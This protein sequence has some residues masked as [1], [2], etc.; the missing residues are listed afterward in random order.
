[1]SRA[2]VREVV[3]QFGHRL[4]PGRFVR[5]D[6]GP[7]GPAIDK[8]VRLYESI[9][10]IDLFSNPARSLLD[11]ISAL[12]VSESNGFYQ[13][14]GWNAALGLMLD[15]VPV[16]WLAE[17]YHRRAIT[18]SNRTKRPD[19]MSDVYGGFAQH[20][21]FLGKWDR[22]LESSQL[23]AEKAWDSGQLHE[24]GMPIYQI[25]LAQAYRGTL[26]EALRHCQDLIRCG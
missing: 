10:W 5:P 23:A 11:A 12:N 7:V 3:R 19:V 17:N 20:N 16:Y 24:W 25:T 1:V 6:S 8:Q 21:L 9:F 26:S 13:V 22:M 2:I 18:L 4:L 14:A 15:F